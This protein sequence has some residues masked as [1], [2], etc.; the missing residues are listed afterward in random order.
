[1]FKFINNIIITSG[2]NNANTNENNINN[3]T[4]QQPQQQ[5]P[6]QPS[7][8]SSTTITSQFKPASI[9]SF[10]DKERF[11]SSVGMKSTFYSTAK[12]SLNAFMNTTYTSFSQLSSTNLK[13][14]KNKYY[15]LLSNHYICHICQ[16]HSIGTISWYLS[17]PW[18]IKKD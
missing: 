9:P 8:I 7:N 17:F 4:Q 16:Q 11:R 18:R 10:K 2:V 13:P 1:M 3:N 14:L 12:T 15:E 5:Q 6:P